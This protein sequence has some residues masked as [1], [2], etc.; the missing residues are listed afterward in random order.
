M[1]QTAPVLQAF[2]WKTTRR[3]IF[4]HVIYGAAVL[5]LCAG[6]V[7]SMPRTQAGPAPQAADFV[8]KTFHFSL[9]NPGLLCAGRDYP[10]RATVLVDFEIPGGSQSFQDRVVPGISIVSSTDNTA[11]VTVT[12]AKL[13]S[14]Y[15]QADLLASPPFGNANGLGEVVFTLHAKKAG[16]ANVNLQATIP[17]ALTGSAS[18][19]IP[20]Q[21]PLTVEN[22][23]YEVTVD[24][25]WTAHYPNLTT[26]L[27]ENLHGELAK[28]DNGQLSG[29]AGV[30]WTLAS[31]SALCP[32]K[33]VTSPGQA[34]L[35][36]QQNGENLNLTIA[37]DEFELNTVNCAS[38][39]KGKIPVQ[40]INLRGVPTTGFSTGTTLSFPVG[41]ELLFGT[42]TI[43]IKP[44]ATK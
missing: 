29:T 38:S 22:C 28:D 18:Q 41:N 24:G 21:A 1:N 10:L 2:F 19:V 16:L 42:G 6:G 17:G 11:V 9:A 40:T 31:Y 25:L 26:I 3:S 32:H 8:N 4:W 35:S 7:S 43:T 37:Y 15:V 34:T 20:V 23:Q 33:H 30:F 27:I 5:L 44:V 39:S 13:S 12:P 14:G 36:A